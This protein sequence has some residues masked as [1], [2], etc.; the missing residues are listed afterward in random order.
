MKYLL[1]TIFFLAAPFAHAYNPVEVSTELP[2]EEI[3]IQADEH[4]LKQSYLGTLEGYPEMY[5][6]TLAE[7]SVLELQVKQRAAKDPSLFNLILVSVN[8][9][10]GRIKEVLRVNSDIEEREKVFDWSLGISLLK[11]E[12]AEIQVPEGMYRLEVSTPINEGNY[13]LDFGIE[14]NDNSYFGTFGTVWQV[15]RHFD[16]WWPR[17]LLSSFIFYQ[18][19]ILLM[20]GGF[21]YVWRKRKE[22]NNDS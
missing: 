15:Q 18:L 7:D 20:I 2:F 9:D 13:E 12:V 21:V 17:Y 3:V 22:T 8:P 4:G 1:I 5:E 16:Y 6:F 11:S 10:T 19:G 14:S